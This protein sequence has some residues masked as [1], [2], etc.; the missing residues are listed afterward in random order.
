MPPKHLILPTRKSRDSELLTQACFWSAIAVTAIDE[1]DEESVPG[2]CLPGDTAVWG[3]T[4]FC[5]RIAAALG[6]LILEPAD[7]FLPRLPREYTNR[8]VE[9][10]TLAQ[11]RRLGSPKFIKPVND[12]YF[13]AAV[14]A[15]GADL[16]ETKAGDETPALV[17]DPVSWRCEYRLF[18]REREVCANSPYSRREGT[19]ADATEHAGALSFAAYL[20][21]DRRVMLPRAVVLDVGWIEG[22]GWSVVEA[23]PAVMSSIYGCDPLAVLEVLSDGIVAA[24]C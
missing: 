20:L 24:E 16:P 1:G 12:K 11:A 9:L 10:M 17:S 18:V 5:R 6:G 23:N 8:R 7:D 15:S 14:Y 22:A 4:T 3:G 13:P 21:A 2:E 19:G